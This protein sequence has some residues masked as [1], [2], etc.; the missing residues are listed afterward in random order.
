MELHV[1]VDF[2][3]DALTAGFPL[4]RRHVDGMMRV[5]RDLGVSRVRWAYYADEQGGRVFPD[6]LVDGRSQYAHLAAT[7]RDLG[8]PL[9]TAAECAHRH[10][11]EIF[12]YFK[13]YEG[14]ALPLPEGSEEAKRYG[15]ISHL[16]GPIAWA[17][18]FVVQHPHLRIRRRQDDAA[19]RPS[20]APV[21]SLRLVKKDAAP[22]RVTKDRLQI[23]TSPDNGRY[24]QREIPFPL[25]EDL[26]PAPENVYDVEGNLLT[27]K[28]APRRVLTLSGFSLADRYLLV[29]T[30]FADG[31]GDFANSGL[32]LIRARD[33]T[34]AVIPGSFAT[35]RAVWMSG[36]VDFRRWG[37]IYDY[38]WTGRLTT[39]DAPNAK[40]RQGLIA[41]TRGRNEFLTGA[42]CETE[43][44]VMEF[45]LSRVREMLDA[46]VDG[47]EFREENHSTHTDFPS[48][49]GF[50][51]C[52]LRACR[53][54]ELP[55]SPETVAEVRGEAYTQWLR[56]ARRLVSS[57]GK[58]MSYN[59]NMDW[60]RPDRPPARALAYPAHI[61]FQWR[62]WLAE[63][64]L[65]EST[66]RA[67]A[68]RRA[69]LTDEVGRDMVQV[70]RDRGLPV[71]YNH[72]VFSDDP[73]YFEEARRVL[74]DGRF[75]GLILYEANNFL[76][77]EPDGRVGVRLPGIEK[78]ASLA[79]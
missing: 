63:G 59:L 47:V 72:H 9:R 31:P 33:A 49:Y 18:P 45:W 61:R 13:P 2:P 65:D 36:R 58:K 35:G 14:G 50:N 53:E 8:S 17:D 32:E 16:G 54:R 55:V 44:A 62:Q 21:C 60:F 67:Y 66:L 42:L 10:G 11:L 30:D 70:C 37:L 4:D 76:A 3:D 15:L 71:Y 6:G 46:G 40:G 57:R 12:G 43:P 73:W 34:G 78:I 39:L 27:P 1:L 51:D 38:G 77:Y 26:E 20:D 28:G 48:D 7:Y 22:T 56:R 68:L 74:R 41:Y 24:E 75:A 5:L 79:G 19:A 29:T 25:D 64:L 69:M 23:W 52:V